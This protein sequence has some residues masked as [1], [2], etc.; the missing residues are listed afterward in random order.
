[1]INEYNPRTSFKPFTKES[2]A[3]T[4]LT[5]TLT[6]ASGQHVVLSKLGVSYSGDIT[7]PET[8]EIKVN[9]VSVWKDYVYADDPYSLDFQ[10]G[11]GTGGKDH[12]MTIEV[13]A[14]GGVLKSRVNGIVDKTTTMT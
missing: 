11:L 4:A 7:G 2:A 3:D 10:E 1:M 14:L 8:V 6:P 12:V 5:V 13:S 9:A